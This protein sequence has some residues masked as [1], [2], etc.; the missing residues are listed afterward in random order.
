MKTKKRN[1]KLSTLSRLINKLNVL[2]HKM[3]SANYNNYFLSDVAEFGI[4]SNMETKAQQKIAKDLTDKFE[5]EVRSRIPNYTN[6][7]KDSVGNYWKKLRKNKKFKLALAG[8]T[9]LAG[10]QALS[11]IYAGGKIINGLT[12]GVKN[13]FSKND[14]RKYNDAK[15]SAN[16]VNVRKPFPNRVRLSNDEIKYAIKTGGIALGIPLLGGYAL[17]KLSKRIK[18]NQNSK[19]QYQLSNRR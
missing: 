13:A 7:V 8:Y 6:E 4:L 12:K 5:N 2:R 16:L 15:F 14:K 11:G 17:H 19:T 18:R 1:D 10:L 9:G 3:R